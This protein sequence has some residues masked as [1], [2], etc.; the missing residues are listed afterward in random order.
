LPT[1]AHAESADEAA[2]NK[3]VDDLNKAMIKSFRMA[4]ADYGY[5]A[6][7]FRKYA[8]VPDAA[9]ASDETLKPIWQKLSTAIKAWPNDGGFKREY[10]KDLLPVYRKA[11]AIKGAPDL[12]RVVETRFVEQALQE[13]G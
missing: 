6:D 1:I 11:G 2:V 10:F 9:K 12:N 4:N 5:W 3:A 13:L 8:T 7:G